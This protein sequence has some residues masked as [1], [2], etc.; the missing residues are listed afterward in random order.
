MNSRE[1]QE[2]QKAYFE[3]YEIDEGYEDLPVDKMIA[4]S[5]SLSRKPKP[6]GAPRWGPNDEAASTIKKVA[7]THSRAKV[8]K[9]E[10]QNRE[11]GT[12]KEQ[13]D[14]YDVILSH[15]LDE[16]YADTLEAAEG[17]MVSM[18]EEWREEILD[19]A[20]TVMS[21]SSPSGNSRELNKAKAKPSRNL[22]GQERL[23]AARD[24]RQKD[25]NRRAPEIEKRIK[26]RHRIRINP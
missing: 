15:L 7:G 13:V 2:I 4:K 16:G 8:K 9:V 18:S 22:E 17:I 26:G 6:P 19:E 21:V 25:V 10:Q 14:L 12:Q 11:R 20:N 1:Y 3:V 5:K 24:I 23:A